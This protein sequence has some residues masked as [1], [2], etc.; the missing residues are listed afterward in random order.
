MINAMNKE[1]IF[2]FCIAYSDTD[3]GG[4]VY[5]GRYIE[6]A[7][8]ARMEWLGDLVKPTG[9]DVGFVVNGLDIKYLNPLFL[10][11]RFV[12]KSRVVQFGSVFVVIEQKFVKNDKICAI[13][14][15]KVVYLN[16]DLRPV[17]LPMMVV[18]KLKQE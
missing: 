4:I 1:H 3:A 6:I 18:S 10:M 16:A 14:N 11:D 8:R 12:V 2:N 5:H 17:R 15:V 7:E 9:S 13:L